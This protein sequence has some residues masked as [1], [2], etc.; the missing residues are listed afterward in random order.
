M[1]EQRDAGVE[2]EFSKVDE[3]FQDYEARSNIVGLYDLAL[4]VARRN[5]KLWAKINDSDTSGGAG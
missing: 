1:N 4:K 5:P 2:Q 3:I